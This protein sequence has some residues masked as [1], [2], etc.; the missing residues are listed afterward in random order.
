MKETRNAKDLLFQSLRKLPK[1]RCGRPA[2]Y[3]IDVIMRSFHDNHPDASYSDKEITSALCSL[4]K[5]GKIEELE[6]VR[7]G[8]DKYDNIAYRISK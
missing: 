3:S 8:Q 4:V 2:V 7:I 6:F 1:E 5:E